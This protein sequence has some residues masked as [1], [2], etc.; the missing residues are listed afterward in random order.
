MLEIDA[1]DGFSPAGFSK[2]QPLRRRADHVLP[3]RDNLCVLAAP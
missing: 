1:L 3:G 2:V